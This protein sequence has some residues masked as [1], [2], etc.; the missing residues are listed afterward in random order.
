MGAV[1]IKTENST[2]PNPRKR[3]FAVSIDDD[4]AVVN[5]DNCY[6]THDRRSVRMVE[7]INDF[8]P[9][10]GSDDKIIETNSDGEEIYEI[11]APE[12]FFFLDYT[13]NVKE[14]LNQNFEDELRLVYPKGLKIVVGR[15]VSNIPKYFQTFEA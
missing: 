10:D 8:N 15:L 6:L 9:A 14:E 4:S 2:K 5:S 13:T 11:G 12:G 1:K 3:K 7:I